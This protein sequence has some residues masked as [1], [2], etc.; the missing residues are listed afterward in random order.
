MFV[1]E[2]ACVLIVSV[3]FCIQGC[4]LEC[5]YVSFLCLL[6]LGSVFKISLS[7]FCFRLS[8]RLSVWNAIACLVCFCGFA[9]R[10]LFFVVVCVGFA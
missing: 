9:Q 4:L 7:F 8:L 3:V 2:A 6:V 10:F 1:S 5:P